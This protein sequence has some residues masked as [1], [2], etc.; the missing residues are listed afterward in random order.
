M[1]RRSEQSAAPVQAIDAC[2]FHEWP[3][4]AAL[5]PYLP[6]GWRELLL[7]PRT[8][9]S[10]NRLYRNLLSDGTPRVH[11]YEDLLSRVLDAGRRERVVLSS[12]DGLL[13][14]ANVNHF[15]SQAIALGLNRWTEEEW[16]A[17]DERVYGLIVAPGS[18]PD[19]AAKEIRRSGENTRMVGVVLGSAGLGAPLGHPAYH[20]IY[21]AA[22]DLGLPIVLQVGVDATENAVA[23]PIAGGLPATAGE[24][25]ALSWHA[26]AAHVSNLIM[27]GV[28]DRFPTL[29]VLLLGAGAVW[30][31]GHLW[32]MDHRFRVT[33]GDGRWLSRRPIDYV[34]R[35]LFSTFR[36]ER[37]PRPELLQQALS[38]IPNIEERLVYASGFPDDD[39]QDIDTALEA[40][41][42]AWR[43]AVLREN[44]L[45]FFRWP[46][47]SA[48][49]TPNVIANAT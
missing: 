42:D 11:D 43:S 12:D 32:R 2:V 25:R 19:E 3:T 15:V 41:P 34:D 49:P 30:F 45:D 47:R 37:P 24:Y 6:G 20:P 40:I 21:E 5:A 17:R 8:I 46:D 9:I 48:A 23:T 10:S 39:S 38:T 7:E 27:Q 18:L 29:R 28:F 13:A 44:A 36:L 14:T 22:T 33:R 26:Q 16:L 35:F 4:I 1:A 31:P